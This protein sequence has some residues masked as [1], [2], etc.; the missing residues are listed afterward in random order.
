M[1]ASLYELVG[2]RRTALG[3]SLP[4]VT[5]RVAVKSNANGWSVR[6][7]LTGQWQCKWVVKS[8]QLRN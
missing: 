8:M 5:R 4:I 7:Q 2:K 1:T 3:R 6:M